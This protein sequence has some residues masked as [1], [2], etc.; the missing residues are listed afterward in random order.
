MTRADKP[1][2]PAGPTPTQRLNQAREVL[3]RPATDNHPNTTARDT[4][5]TTGE[6]SG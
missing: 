6:P 1:F 5:G 4:T 3:A 2:D